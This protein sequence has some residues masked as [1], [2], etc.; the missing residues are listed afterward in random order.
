MNWLLR[1]SRCLAATAALTLAATTAQAQFEKG[2]MNLSWNDCGTFGSMQRNFACNSNSG[3]NIM[4]AS[5]MVIV[6][7]PQFNGM[8]G[9][10][11][12][13]TNQVA[14]SNWW[15]IGNSG[16]PPSCRTGA[17]VTADFNF[18]S[19]INC[20]DPWGGAAAGGINYAYAGQAANRARIRTV[21]AIAGSTPLAVN[22]EHYF[23]KVSIN[24]SRSTGTGSCSGCQD[25]ACIVLSSIHLTQPAGQGDHTLDV[26]LT[27]QFIQWQSDGDV[28]G[29]CPGATPTRTTTW[30]S[31]KSLYR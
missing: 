24:N 20:L 23:F 8:A 27:R 31:V 19:N 7:M 16:P 1:R 2:A 6:P 30:G 10:I 18:T 21:C 15:K 22:L 25:G 28:H 14:L 4:Y 5:G 13:Q 9:V 26:P 11:D 12:L 29:G 3:I 17:T